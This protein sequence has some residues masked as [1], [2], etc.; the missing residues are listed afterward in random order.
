MKKA[1]YVA[2]AA[3]GMALAAAAGTAKKEFGPWK[4]SDFKISGSERGFV[5]GATGLAWS[6]FAV[7][8][9]DGYRVFEDKRIVDREKGSGSNAKDHSFCYEYSW[10]D[11][12][13][14]T[15]WAKEIGY[16]DEDKFGEAIFTDNGWDAFAGLWDELYDNGAA[17]ELTFDSSFGAQLAYPLHY[18]GVATLTVC[19]DDYNW[20]G[21]KGDIAHAVVCTG[22]S[23]DPS[24][25]I[26]DP[27]WLKGLFIIDPDNDRENGKGG[28]GAPDTITY[29]PASWDASKKRWTVRNVFGATGYLDPEDYAEAL[30]AAKSGTLDLTTDGTED[31]DCDSCGEDAEDAADIA[32]FFAKAR[33][34]AGALVDGDGNVAG[35][36]TVKAGKADKKGKVKF[37]ASA[38]L[39]DG[40]K[41]TAKATTL[42]LGAGETGGTFVFKAPVGEI[43]FWIDEDSGEIDFAGDEYGFSAGTIGGKLETDVLTFSTDGII[44]D[45]SPG[46]GWEWVE[47]ALPDGMEITVKNGAK[48]AVPKTSTPKYAKVKEDGETWYELRGVGDEAKPNAAALKL[49]YNAKTGMLKGSFKLYATNESVTPDGKAPKLKAFTATITGIV[50]DGECHAAATCKALDGAV[51][52]VYLEQW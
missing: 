31:D 15:G 36:M 12:M 11:M 38:A 6:D 16:T 40:K 41:F 21:M 42:N 37:S 39:L 8:K 35:T 30:T 33:T 45:V 52:P 14:H 9:Y 18:G 50:I 46:D 23:Y 26:S 34:I 49:A 43:D 24:K 19:F 44:F 51:W 1:G 32:A 20:Y 28:A 22:Y 13:I 5:A 48:L 17:T 7:R 27:A 4:A 10:V 47:D 2:L 3:A 25:Q 29:C